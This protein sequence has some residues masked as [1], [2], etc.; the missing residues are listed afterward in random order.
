MKKPVTITIKP[1]LNEIILKIKTRTTI[2]FTYFKESGLVITINQHNKITDVKL[3]LG[4]E[5]DEFVEYV[6]FLADKH[7]CNESI[8]NDKYKLNT[9]STQSMVLKIQ[10]VDVYI[11]SDNYEELLIFVFKY[12]KG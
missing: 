5:V 1:N 3:N 9:C 6:L 8:I 10:D 7:Y 4:A 11:Q 12:I 2:S